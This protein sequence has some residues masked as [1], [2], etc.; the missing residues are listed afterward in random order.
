[1][2]IVLEILHSGGTLSRQRLDTLPLTVGRSLGNDVILDDPY[3][4][5]QHARIALDETGA[6]R[7]EDLGSV[8]GLVTREER[9]R[10]AVHLVVG[11]EVRVGRTTL[12]FRDS[13]E[14]VS[15]AL[16]DDRPARAP[17]PRRDSGRRGV[18]ARG[19]EWASSTVGHI[20][21]SV[22]VL[23]MIALQ[24]WFGSADRSSVSVAFGGASA[25][26]AVAALWAGVWAVASRSNVQR[27]NFMGHYAFVSAIGLAT[28]LWGTAGEWLNFF[29]PD[30][31]V[32]EVLSAG[33]VVA[34]FCALIAGHLSMSS[35]MT[36]A[37]R[38]RAGA[39]ISVAAVGL[40]GLAA[41]VTEDSFSDVP[42]FSGILKPVAA[43]WIP[44]ATV[45]EYGRVM[46]NLK[47]DVDEMTTRE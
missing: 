40:T 23:V 22:A 18:A 24:S 27:F 29:F 16:P 20:V 5:G 12:R 6:L 26:A 34:L 2:A 17:A 15:P 36:R 3:V 8:N 32:I 11:A 28:L 37:S 9:I 30:A 33:I 25:F 4:E 42:T 35:T 39:I 31:A 45:D 41:L 7:I 13:N 47:N 44:T 43:G 1:M 19:V 46:L 21:I 38:W 10:G 14:P